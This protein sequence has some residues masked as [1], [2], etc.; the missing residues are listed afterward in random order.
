MRVDLIATC[1]SLGLI[2][3]RGKLRRL[4][5]TPCQLLKSILLF[6]GEDGMVAQNIVSADFFTGQW[7]LVRCGLRP[8]D[9]DG[10][11]TCLFLPWNEVPGRF[12]VGFWSVPGRFLVNFR[13]VSGVLNSK[14]YAPVALVAEIRYERT[15]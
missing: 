13:L 8:M 3:F 7:M 15:G 11:S 4:L 12:P 6:A 10:N 2:M 9:E 5:R 14:N 1:H